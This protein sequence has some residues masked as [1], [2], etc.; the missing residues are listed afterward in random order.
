MPSIPTDKTLYNNVKRE[1]KNKFHKWP[2]AYASGW[3]VKE[4]KRQ[5]GT[6]KGKKPGKSL[7]LERWFSEK[8]INVC[9]LPK[10]VSCGRGKLNLSDWKK[11]YPYCRPSVRVNS[12]TPKT[13]DELTKTQLDKKCMKKKK[14]PLSRI[15]LTTQKSPKRR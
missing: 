15:R 10:K 6:Y 12:K 14:S 5:G 9:K 7:G 1:A 13:I 3:L 2:S 8:W 11:T 4:Y